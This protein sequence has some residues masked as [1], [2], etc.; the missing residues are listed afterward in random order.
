[1]TAVYVIVPE[2][3][4]VKSARLLAAKF[5]EGAST[6]ASVVD[7]P[8]ETSTV[9]DVPEPPLAGVVIDWNATESTHQSPIRSHGRER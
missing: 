2:N 7:R 6:E 5:K 9:P 3:T 8:S 1:L 4:V